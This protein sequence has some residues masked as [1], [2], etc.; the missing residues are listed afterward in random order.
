MII[1]FS[2]HGLKLF[3]FQRHKRCRTVVHVWLTPP[4]EIHGVHFSL[5]VVHQTQDQVHDGALGGCK[6]KGVTRKAAHWTA[7]RKSYRKWSRVTLNI[8]ISWDVP[9][10]P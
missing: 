1:H 4:R 9:R 3:N 5:V 10:I 6:A 8:I 7:R 2:K